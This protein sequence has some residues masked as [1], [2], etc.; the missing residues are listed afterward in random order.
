MYTN[1]KE[2]KYA[3]YHKSYVC[4]RAPKVKSGNN[5]VRIADKQIPK[6]LLSDIPNMPLYV[7]PNMLVCVRS[8]YCVCIQKNSR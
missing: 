1:K 5:G 4:F 7:I 3:V 2:K 8:C 6:S